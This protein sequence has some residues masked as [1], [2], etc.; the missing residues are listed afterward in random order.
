MA[1]TNLVVTPYSLRSGKPGVGYLKVTGTEVVATAN[2]PV[3]TS[4]IALDT[5]Y[6]AVQPIA[7]FANAV[8]GQAQAAAVLVDSAGS[9]TLAAASGSQIKVRVNSTT[10][11]SVNFCIIL[12]VQL[13]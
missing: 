4:V 7:V 8:T 11:E 1:L 13:S 5:A 2:T 10:A 12:E 3:T 9:P 6:K